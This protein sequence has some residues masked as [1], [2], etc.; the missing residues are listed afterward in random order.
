[1]KSWSRRDRSD[2]DRLLDRS[3]MVPIGYVEPSPV[4]I[5]ER[6]VQFQRKETLVKSAGTE[7]IIAKTPEH[8]RQLFGRPPTQA[9]IKINMRY[10][11]AKVDLWDEVIAQ[12]CEDDRRA[13][14][15]GAERK[16]AERKLN[17][18]RRAYQIGSIT[19][20]LCFLSLIIWLLSFSHYQPLVF[21]HQKPEVAK[22]VIVHELYDPAQ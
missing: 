13:A 6:A 10:W 16:K 22:H 17:R 7:E 1:M 12:S 15:A 8:F 4:E 20:I 11:G 9:E 19:F 18:E 5:L 3:A 14:A 2:F 21:P